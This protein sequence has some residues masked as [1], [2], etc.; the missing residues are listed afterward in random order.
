MS[1][2]RFQNL[3]F[4][5]FKELAKNETLSPHEKIGN[6]DSYRAGKE[7][8]IFDDIKLKVPNLIKNNQIVVDIGPG[9]G[10]LALLL[11]EHCIANKNT[12]ILIDSAEMLE[13][14]PNEKTIIKIPAYYPDECQ[15]LFKEYSQKVNVVLTYS[16][17]HYV[18]KEGNLFRFLDSTLS[19]LSDEGEF[20]IGDIP[21]I[22]KRKRFFSSSTGIKFHQKFMKTEEKPKVAFNCSDPGEIDDAVLFSIAMRSRQA[23]FDAYLLPQSDK[24]PMANRREDILIRRP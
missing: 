22:S 14:L 6:P 13:Q 5:D 2:E 17:L 3:S 8:E 12:L 21:N 7:S 16:V 18:F 1:L 20:L 10:A 9:C 19:L 11:I 15:Q 23:G 24:L 4:A